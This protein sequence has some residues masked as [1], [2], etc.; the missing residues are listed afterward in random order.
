MITIDTTGVL[1]A[2]PEVVWKLITD[3]EHQGDWMLEAKDFKVLTE[4]REG[5]GVEAEATVSIGGISTR[6]RVRV[7][8]WDP[9]QRLEI[10]HDGW[11]SGRGEFKLTPVGK[12][13]THVFWREELNP[14]LGA[15]GTV[16]MNLFR[17]M[18]SRLFKRD[19]R[20]LESLCRVSH[21]AEWS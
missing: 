11:V 17:P 5:V 15:L 14:P 12:D 16:G 1:P 21:V 6:D 3:W 19:L 9:P 20:I 13:R 18:M 2:P 10:E 7:S 8:G 4:H